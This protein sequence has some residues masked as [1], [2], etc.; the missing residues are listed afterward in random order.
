MSAFVAYTN[1]L[2]VGTAHER[3]VLDGI[4]PTTKAGY[5]GKLLNF[6]EECQGRGF[7]FHLNSEDERD[8]FQELGAESVYELGKSGATVEGLRCAILKLHSKHRVADSWTTRRDVLDFAKGLRKRSGR[9]KILRC[10][11]PRVPLPWDLFRLLLVTCLQRGR[12]DLAR[13]YFL[14]YIGLFRENHLSKI[15]RADIIFTQDPTHVMIWLWGFKSEDNVMAGHYIKMVGFRDEMETWIG[16][17]DWQYD[18]C[19]LPDWNAEEAISYLRTFCS[20]VGLRGFLVDLHSL[21]TSGVNALEK[22][23]VKEASIKIQGKWTPESGRFEE[24]Y[25]SAASPEDQVQME[26]ETDSPTR[27]QINEKLDQLPLKF[28]K[29]QISAN[30]AVGL[31]LRRELIN[32]EFG[33]L[34]SAPKS[35]PP[36]VAGADS[37]FSDKKEILDKLNLQ[38]PTPNDKLVAVAQPLALTYEVLTPAEVLETL[39]ELRR[40]R[41]TVY[42]RIVFVLIE[43]VL[44]DGHQVESV[45]EPSTWYGRVES[46]R[47][48]PTALAKIHCTH[49]IVGKDVCAFLD[50]YDE[51]GSYVVVAPDLKFGYIS[52]DRCDDPSVVERRGRDTGS[53][54]LQELLPDQVVPLAPSWAQRPHR[55]VPPPCGSLLRLIRASVA[56]KKRMKAEAPV[57]APPPPKET[58]AKSA[59]PAPIGKRG[60]SLTRFL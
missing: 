29:R 38:F 11:L 41:A 55:A 52:L 1:F 19:M 9:D 35:I 6:S 36:A 47:L 12:R 57:L 7:L 15:L 48:P 54:T 14:I 28:K 32:R 18:D 33:T 26:R 43:R 58:V 34:G 39:R 45:H 8:A 27:H 37:L 56:P 31:R 60:Y 4:M 25:R 16:E 22:M 46:D 51:E 5:Y 23:G 59:P 53:N 13:A 20:A 24:S 40:I 44:S 17:R 42:V 10:V 2:D 50:E 49:Q 21:R 3:G 30:D